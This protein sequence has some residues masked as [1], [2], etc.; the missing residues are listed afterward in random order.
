MERERPPIENSIDNNNH[1]NT[2][3]A[4]KKKHLFLMLGMAAMLASCGQDEL[5]GTRTDG[6]ATITA[7]IDD[8]MGTRASTFDK[9]DVAIDQCLLEVYDAAGSTLVAQAEGVQGAQGGTFTFTVGGLDPE[10]EYDFLFWA[11]NREAAAYAGTLKERKL[12]DGADLSKA[13][14]FQ[15]K[16]EG[17]TADEATSATLT[18]AVAKVTL[19]TTGALAAGDKASISMAGV[20]GTW[21]VLSGTAAG[22]ATAEYAYTLA[23]AIAQAQDA[24]EVTT[25]YVPAPVLGSTSDMTVGYASADGS[26]AGSA[27]VTNVPLKANYR[28]V[29][30]GDVAALYEGATASITAQLN[31]QWSDP[32]SEVEFPEKPGTITTTGVGQITEQA[33]REALQENDG[34]V[35][36]KGYI[37]EYD[38]NVLAAIKDVEMNIDLSQ[39]T[40]MNVG[41]TEAVTTFPD[42]FSLQSYGSVQ[43]KLMSIILPQGIET[44]A[45]NCFNKN[46]SLASVTLPEG[47]KKIGASAFYQTAL[48]SIDLP[49]SLEEIGEYAFRSITELESVIIPESVTAVGEYCFERSGLRNV[50][51]NSSCDIATNVFP[52]IE[53]L[54]TVTLNKCGTIAKGAFRRS[55]IQEMIVNIDTP[56]MFTIDTE[57]V[58]K[59]VINKIYVPAASVETYKATPDWS[60]YADV[61][62]AIQ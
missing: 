57:P 35:I 54:E 27:N 21:D 34:T 11:D 29:L 19:K 58:N 37:S 20:A 33:V 41:G 17:A 28:T 39:A 32:D 22:D 14:A 42:A 7:T 43:N 23:S 61:I 9:D 44:L 6:L 26:K 18:H 15:G 52:Y 10:A 30:K 24:A 13:L 25:F 38:L 56:P 46:K 47:L 31:S 40:L 55:T 8:G 50:V 2:N 4:M 60:E 49:E 53:T 1:T 45:D 51:W 5:G 3:E 62:S 12:A 16:I 59:P 48:T 36:I